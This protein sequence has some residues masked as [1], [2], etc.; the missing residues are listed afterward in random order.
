M[1]SLHKEKDATLELKRDRKSKWRM[2]KKYDLVENLLDAEMREDEHE[3]SNYDQEL[4]EAKSAV[5]DAVFDH[6]LSDTISAFF[7]TKTPKSS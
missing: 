5:A 3:W 6:L 7:K 2:K 1:L 4:C